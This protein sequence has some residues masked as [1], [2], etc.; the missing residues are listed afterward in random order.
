MTHFYAFLHFWP[1]YSENKY[2]TTHMFYDL[3]YHGFV[4]QNPN[5]PKY[6]RFLRG[7]ELDPRGYMQKVLGKHRLYRVSHTKQWLTI[8]NFLCQFFYFDEFSRILCI[9]PANWDQP[10]CFAYNKFPQL[11]ILYKICMAKVHA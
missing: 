2:P 4:C 5:S 3:L 11:L 8:S 6:V 10:G 9:S 1:T 7:V